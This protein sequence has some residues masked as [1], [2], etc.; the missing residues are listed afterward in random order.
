MW[1]FW[2]YE[3]L[4]LIAV[5]V[6]ICGYCRFRGIGF[7]SFIWKYLKWVTLAVLIV[8]LAIA[9]LCRGDLYNAAHCYF[10]GESMHA[11]TKYSIFLGECQVETPSGSYV[12][13]ERARALPGSNHHDSDN[14]SDSTSEFYPVN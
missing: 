13:I 14:N 2:L 12:P 3:C 1:L 6:L 5:I 8:W 10:R 9:L 7:W 4:G 11:N